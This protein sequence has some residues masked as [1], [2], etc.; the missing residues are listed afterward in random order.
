MD[1]VNKILRYLKGWPGKEILFSNHVNRKV[2]GFNDADSAK[3]LDA[4]KSTLATVCL[5]EI[6]WCDGEVRNKA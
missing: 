6:T 5:L 1:A 3:K 4:R 2:E